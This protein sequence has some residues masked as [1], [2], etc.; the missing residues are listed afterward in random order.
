MTKPEI[1]IEVCNVST[2]IIHAT[3]NNILIL[4]KEIK[5]VQAQNSHIRFPCLDLSFTKIIRLIGA[6]FNNLNKVEV[7]VAKR[8]SFSI[9]TKFPNF[10]E[11]IKD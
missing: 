5:Q 1:G 6:S 2:K 4:N 10:M 11:L 9:T 3:I 7:K 8:Y